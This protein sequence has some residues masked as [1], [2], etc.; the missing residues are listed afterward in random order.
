MAIV[1]IIH[2]ISNNVEMQYL[3]CRNLP[4]CLNKVLCFTRSSPLLH[5][6]PAY[7]SD[8]QSSTVK[9]NTKQANDF[10]K[11]FVFAAPKLMMVCKLSTIPSQS[12][13]HRILTEFVQSDKT[14]VCLIVVNMQE[15]SKRIVNH[16]RIMIETAERENTSKMFILLL[17][18]PPAQ[19]FS[20]CYPSLFMT[21][22]NHC[23]L[24]T[25]AHNNVEGCVNIK[26]WFW[27]CYLP[28]N[29]DDDDSLTIALEELLPQA[30]PVLS[31]RVICGARTGGSFNAP[32]KHPDFHKLL[33]HLIFERSVGSKL[34]KRFRAYWKP[35]I[36]AEYLER[37]ASFTKSQ[38]STL[39]ITDSI[40]TIFKTLFFDF[41]VYMVSRINEHFNIDVL[42][43]TDTTAI[44]ELFLEILEV[45]PVPNLAQVNVMSVNLP[46]PQPTSYAPSFQFF[47]FVSNMM[48]KLVEQCQEEANKFF[49]MIPDEESESI[50]NENSEGDYNK[51]SLMRYLYTEVRNRIMKQK[52]VR[53]II[54]ITI[55]C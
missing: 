36:M 25:I 38:E 2:V 34:C 51:R 48:D 15:T 1:I 3:F 11:K 12:S 14:K 18:F 6:L 4:T 23:Y 55:L 5:K 20:P 35:S 27:Q 32:M 21:G 31:S 47:H 29:F 39:N 8:S 9:T 42:F 28:Q 17:H 33:H 13:I 54:F 7:Y 41:L 44:H 45:F 46:T 10:L 53:T 22:W 24:D 40:Q 16:L 43:D 49:G 26:D 50:N 30:I 52:N 19:F 37:A